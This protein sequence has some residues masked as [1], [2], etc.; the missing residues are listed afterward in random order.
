MSKHG[1]AIVNMLADMWGGMPGMGHSARRVP[2]WT[3]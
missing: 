3:T 2:A 1:G